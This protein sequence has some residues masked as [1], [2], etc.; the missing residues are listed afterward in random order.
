[1]PLA[2]EVVVLREELGDKVVLAAVDQ[3]LVEVLDLEINGHLMLLV[4]L[5]LLLVK[6]TMVDVIAA[7]LDLMVEGA[8]ALVVLEVT[9][10]LVLVMVGLLLPT[11]SLG[12]LS[13]ILAGAEE[14]MV[15]LPHRVQVVAKVVKEETVVVPLVVLELLE[16]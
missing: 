8:A 15:V 3:E 11:A 6:V 7:A 16:R 1:M 5:V 4:S 13:I 9:L 10:V 14:A 2:V 12:H